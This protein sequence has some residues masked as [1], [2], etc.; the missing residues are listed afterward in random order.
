ML[1]LLVRFPLLLHALLNDVS[2]ARTVEECAGVLE[3]VLWAVV[4]DLGDEE[5]EETS[6]LG[7]STEVPLVVHSELQLHSKND[8]KLMSSYLLSS[9]QSHFSE[10]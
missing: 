4:K 5:L 7:V 8:E 1:G 10:L 3:H 6:D 2:Q 9:F